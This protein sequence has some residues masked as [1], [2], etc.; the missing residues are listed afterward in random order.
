V[1]L[2]ERFR[3]FRAELCKLIEPSVVFL[4]Q[5]EAKEILLPH[6]YDK[7]VSKKTVYEKNGQLLKYILNDSFVGDYAAVLDA[8]KKTDQEHVVNFITSNG[9]LCS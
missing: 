1:E 2:G 8:L 4:C 7:V 5:L 9:G 3:S 6:Q